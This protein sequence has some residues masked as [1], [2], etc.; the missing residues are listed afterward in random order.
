M[1]LNTSH[2]LTLALF[3]TAFA[4][5]PFGVDPWPDTCPP[6]DKHCGPSPTP[7][8]QP[9]IPDECTPL[10]VSDPA[11]SLAGYTMY[12]PDEKRNNPLA[13]EPSYVYL[14]AGTEGVILAGPSVT[15]AA[16]LFTLQ[17]AS[18]AKVGLRSPPDDPYAAADGY[19]VVV[20]RALKYDVAISDFESEVALA[21]VELCERNGKIESRFFFR[22]EPR[23]DGVAHQ[24]TITATANGVASAPTTPVTIE[25]RKP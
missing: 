16:G 1:K 7:D 6:W 19:K 14:V 15:S 25:V 13:G 9:P 21:K 20:N 10:V 17:S 2:L 8:A 12:Q 4:G 24:T 11:V 3:S 23:G 22:G 5:C 18:I